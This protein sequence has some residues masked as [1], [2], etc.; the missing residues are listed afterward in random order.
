[1]KSK[2]PNSAVRLHSSEILQIERE[3]GRAGEREQERI[4]R[5]GRKRKKE[6]GRKKGEKEPRK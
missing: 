3:D 4:R 5:K 2:S 6:T 1:M